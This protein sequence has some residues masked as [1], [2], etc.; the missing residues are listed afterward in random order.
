MLV[1][2]TKKL[3]QKGIRGALRQRRIEVPDC[4]GPVGWSQAHSFFRIDQDYPEERSRLELDEKRPCF[5]AQGEDRPPCESSG[6]SLLVYRQ[7]RVVRKA[8]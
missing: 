1:S 7:G 2:G 6:V 3:V 8:G 5:R 4:N